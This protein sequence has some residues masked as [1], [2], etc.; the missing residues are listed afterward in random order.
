MSDNLRTTRPTDDGGIQWRE[1]GPEAFSEA[2]RLNRPVL[3]NLTAVWCQSC[4]T[5]DQTTYAE[6]DL[7]ALINQSLLPVRA[8]AVQA[9]R[10]QRGSQL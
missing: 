8:D 10:S 5:M 9:G 2:E 4:R 3:L 7:V 1:W 6:P